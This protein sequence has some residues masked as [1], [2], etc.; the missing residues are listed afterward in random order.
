MVAKTT[1]E[2]YEEM[3]DPHVVSLTYKMVVGEGIEFENPAPLEHETDLFSFKL[4]NE[5]LTVMPKVHFS[6]EEEPRAIVRRYLDI[7]EFEHALKTRR[8]NVTFKYVSAKVIDRDQPQPD[9]TLFLY[10]GDIVLAT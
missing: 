9:N 6:K 1:Q 10:T 8:R 5:I 7:W 3:P 2:K 4:E